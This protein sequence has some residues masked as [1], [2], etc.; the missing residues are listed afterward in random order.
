M[1]LIMEF[2]LVATDA[3]IFRRLLSLSGNL[4]NPFKTHF[5]IS[6]GRRLRLQMP[7]F[8]VGPHTSFSALFQ[9]LRCGE[10]CLS[11]TAIQSHFPFLKPPDGRLT[12]ANRLRSGLESWW[13]ELAAFF[14]LPLLLQTQTDFCVPD[15]PAVYA[16]ELSWCRSSSPHVPSPSLYM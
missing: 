1:F 9:S 14:P 12:V 15:C 5:G 13:E 2:K 7:W 10:S 4:K 6:A 3:I 16:S 8:E 11:P